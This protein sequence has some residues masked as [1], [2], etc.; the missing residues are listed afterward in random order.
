VVSGI[1]ELAP[2]SEYPSAADD[3]A[4]TPAYVKAA[5]KPIAPCTATPAKLA[6][7]AAMAADPSKFKVTVCY[8]DGTPAPVSV[9][10]DDLIGMLGG[11]F[12]A[13]PGV[14]QVNFL[15]PVLPFYTFSHNNFEFLRSGWPYSSITVP[16][17]A[18]H[19]AFIS[20]DVVSGGSG[21]VEG[22]GSL[23][24]ICAAAPGDVFAIAGNQLTKNGSTTYATGEV[25]SPV[26]YTGYPWVPG[27]GGTANMGPSNANSKAVLLC[28]VSLA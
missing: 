16:A 7:V 27:H 19:V 26:V 15:G 21:Q 5:I 28:P 24:K 12:V 8:N 18:T 17:G 23:M 6:E 20:P 25:T 14:K 1:V 13:G 3:E 10:G 9:D 22:E 4:A 2:A 11:G